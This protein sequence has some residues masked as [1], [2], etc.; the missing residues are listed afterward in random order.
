MP[1]VF[2]ADPA[3]AGP[4]GVRVPGLRADGPQAVPHPGGGTL[5]Q[6]LSPHHGAVSQYF[7]NN[8]LYLNIFLLM[9]HI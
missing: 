4:A 1:C 5:R 2:P 7:Q 3:A 8:R 6:V 9:L